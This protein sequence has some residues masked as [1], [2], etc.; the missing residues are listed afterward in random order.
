MN[1]NP[2]KRHHVCCG[3]C[4]L[5]ESWNVRDRK[6]MQFHKKQSISML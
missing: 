4:T 1:A 3:D 5:G 2:P 6:G